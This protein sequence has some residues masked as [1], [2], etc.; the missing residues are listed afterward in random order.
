MDR[1]IAVDA[2]GGPGF[3]TA[4]LAAWD[5]GDAVLPV[6][7]RL[8]PPAR[9]ALLGAMSLDQP[10]E[11]GDALVV[12]TSGTT[13]A[14]KGVVLT[15]GAVL[16]HAQAVHERLGVGP[17]DRWLA[18]L[19]LGHIGGLGVVVRALVDDVGLHVRERF[20]VDSLADALRRRATLTSL[21]PTALDR[22][23]PGPWRWI[24]LGGSADPGERPVNV[25]RTYGSTETGGGVVYDGVPLAGTETRVVDDELQVRGPTLLRA[26][27]D[28]SSPLDADGW[29]ATGDLGRIVDGRVHVAGRRGDLI[30]TG[31]E[32]V[33]PD[34]VERAL[35]TH[36]LVADA[37]VA[38][39][40]DAEWGQRV[41]A[42]IVPTDPSE[43]PALDA[44]RDHVSARLPRYCAPR[45]IV[46]VPALPRTPLG[47]IAR[48]GLA[49]GTNGRR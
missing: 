6:D 4:L 23:D 17:T 39:R 32:N 1:L 31:G 7:P 24:V 40:D 2:Q 45:R 8:P 16:A 41:V 27:R 36:P 28:G 25:V 48:S 3:V 34:P 37:A 22:I 35:R 13:G 18:C 33:W 29:L 5:D 47:K 46:L 11:P 12:P 42:W 21:V 43:P 9:R 19:P 26:L 44:L 30:V 14:P 15:H 49:E 20:D 10:V 38:G